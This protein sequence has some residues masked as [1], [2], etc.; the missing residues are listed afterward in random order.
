MKHTRFRLTLFLSAVLLF[1]PLTSCGSRYIEKKYS[2]K[3]ILPIDFNIEEVYKKQIEYDER[4]E[5][6]SNLSSHIEI[7]GITDYCCVYRF[8][9]AWYRYDFVDGV[10]TQI[11]YQPVVSTSQVTRSHG[12]FYGDKIY[13]CC[14]FVAG[15]EMLFNDDSVS[16]APTTTD[17]IIDEID[18]NK[19]RVKRVYSHDDGMYSADNQGTLNNGYIVTSGEQDSCEYLAVVNPESGNTEYTK[20]VDNKIYDFC[21][22]D[23]KVYVFIKDADNK[24][25]YID[26]YNDKLEYLK[27][28]NFSFEPK[29]V[30]DDISKSMIVYKDCLFWNDYAQNSHIS[31]LMPDNTIKLLY[32]NGKVF[33]DVLLCENTDVGV[34]PPVFCS[35]DKSEIFI[36]NDECELTK[37]TLDLSHLPSEGY[38]L[39]RMFTSEN[40]YLLHFYKYSGTGDPEPEFYYLVKKDKIQDV[41]FTAELPNSTFIV[42]IPGPL[43]A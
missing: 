37:I 22:Y 42:D 3:D 20:T 27:T 1:I 41:T 19:N 36:I 17:N 5:I 32:R 7:L 29:G 31:K 28:Y 8:G 18:L 43:P 24:E 26:V 11:G 38:T 4:L 16:F 25:A 39:K 35:P 2:D 34:T 12:V 30:F 23:N 21:V 14:F 15:G 13:D 33:D 6:Y 9:G 10:N 40:Y